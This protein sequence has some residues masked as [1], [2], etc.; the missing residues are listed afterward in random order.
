MLGRRAQALTAGNLMAAQ[1]LVA[2]LS[3]SGV[4]Q[5]SSELTR[6]LALQIVFT[7]TCW[8]PF[9]RFMPGRDGRDTDP[10]LAAF[11]TLTLISPYISG[12]P[13]LIWII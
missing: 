8:L 3:A 1:A 5:A 13:G 9:E 10:G 2:Q 4:L 12:N 11:Y 7:T 6:I